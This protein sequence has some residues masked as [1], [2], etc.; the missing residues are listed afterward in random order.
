MPLSQA[1][2]HLLKAKLVTLKDPPKF[3]NTA[4]PAY[5]PKATCAYHSNATGHNTDNCWALKNKVQDMIEAGEI[6]FDAPKTPNVITAPMPK[7]DNTVNAIMDTIHVYDVKDL[8]TDIK[9]KLM[10]YGL[11][12]SYDP[13]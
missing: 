7:H 13:D 5:D 12:P 11:F 8:S 10:R 9:R 3:A 6:E 4:S 1:L 2:Q